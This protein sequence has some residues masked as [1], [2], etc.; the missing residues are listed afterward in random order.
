MKFM[1]SIGSFPLIYAAI[2]WASDG[3]GAVY[4][5]TNAAAGNSVMVYTRA[6]NGTLTPEGCLPAEAWGAGPDWDRRER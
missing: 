3:P 1:K 2:G 6:G 4:A 5:I